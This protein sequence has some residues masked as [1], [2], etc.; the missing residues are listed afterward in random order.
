MNIGGWQSF[1]ISATLSS[2]SK[3]YFFILVICKSVIWFDIFP[4]FT[5]W[6]NLFCKGS[7][8]LRNV[9]ALFFP[10]S[11]SCHTKS[12][13]TKIHNIVFRL[14]TKSVFW[15][16]KSRGPAIIH[17]TKKAMCEPSHDP[18]IILY[19]KRI[20][21]KNF[22]LATIPQQF[23]NSLATIPRQHHEKI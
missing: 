3:V 21:D 16:P 1:T 19:R 14:V 5:T 7:E 2:A 23:H 13:S 9:I 17:R 6:K 15:V 11:P 22:S 12:G 20:F 18:H 4:K 10:T 8:N